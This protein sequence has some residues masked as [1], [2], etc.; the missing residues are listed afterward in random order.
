M[1]KSEAATYGTCI[2]YFKEGSNEFYLYNGNVWLC[3]P[4]SC[5]DYGKEEDFKRE[6]QGERLNPAVVLFN[7]NKGEKNV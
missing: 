4:H 1:E 6:Y 2:G 3:G 5:I 7:I